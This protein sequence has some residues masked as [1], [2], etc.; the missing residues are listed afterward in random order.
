MG[1]WVQIKGSWYERTGIKA[2][3]APA[4]DRQRR[5]SPDVSAD[6]ASDASLCRWC[7]G[8]PGFIFKRR[9]IAVRRGRQMSKHL[10]GSLTPKS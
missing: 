8:R 7:A 5:H 3:R 9:V 1:P 6:N 10:A 4:K 2:K